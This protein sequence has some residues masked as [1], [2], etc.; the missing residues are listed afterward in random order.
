[1]HLGEKRG[2]GAGSRVLVGYAGAMEWS[3]LTDHVSLVLR[4]LLSTPNFNEK[5]GG[6]LRENVRNWAA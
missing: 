6:F 3:V 5:L 1:M 2:G 4:Y